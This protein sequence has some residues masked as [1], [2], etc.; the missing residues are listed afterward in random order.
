VRHFQAHAYKPKP[1]QLV[2]S[3]PSKEL[4]GLQLLPQLLQVAA[5]LRGVCNSK[6]CR[7]DGQQLMQ[8]EAVGY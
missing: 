1:P 7:E 8:V 2:I 5:L 6:A 3:D 4:G